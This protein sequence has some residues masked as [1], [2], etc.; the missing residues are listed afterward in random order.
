MKKIGLITDSCCD[1]TPGM[2]RVLGARLVSLTITV[3]D[4][5]F[6]D[7]E[8]FDQRRLLAAMK[9]SKT[10]PHTACPAPE[11]YA[12]AMEPYDECYVVTL[13]SRLSGSYA[14]AR[15]GRDIALERHPDKK[16]Y[17]LD[18]KSAAAGETLLA[19]RLRDMIDGEAPFEEVVERIEAFRD[20]MR[21]VFVLEDLSNLV[22][23]GRISRAAGLL[24]G[25][26]GLRPIMGDDGDGNIRLIEK[27][28]GTQNAMRRLVSLLCD[29]LEDA[30]PKSRILAISFCNC[31]ERAL[32]LKKEL[33]ARCPALGDVIVT[34]TAGIST[35][36][37]S[38]GGLVTA[39]FSP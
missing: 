38:D 35:V 16:I 30:R 25:A 6:R 36:Y 22:K 28:R 8:S 19:L 32:A 13:S 1:L 39:F 12:D 34:P 4:A 37:A 20:G 10:P 17:I 23:N 2:R 24:G 5:A 9:Q 3:G 29:A 7:D 33:L 15:S 14:A 18:S 11:A 21:T 27:V 31:A 26:L